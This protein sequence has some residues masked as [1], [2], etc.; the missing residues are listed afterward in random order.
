MGLTQTVYF[1]P[2]AISAKPL[3]TFQAWSDELPFVEKQLEFNGEQQTVLFP[4]K[5]EYGG[6]HC[7]DKDI[8]I[9]SNPVNTILIDF[10]LN[11][12]QRNLEAKLQQYNIKHSHL[13][14]Y[15]GVITYCS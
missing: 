14:Y 7:N 6:V 13:I 2:F 12:L 4:N 3:N 8:A 9:G 1:G 11:N 5:K 15:Y 10:E